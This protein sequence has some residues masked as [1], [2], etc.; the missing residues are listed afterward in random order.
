MGS[1]LQQPPAS[2]QQDLLLSYTSDTYWLK[3]A[4]TPSKNHSKEEEHEML[5]D[6]MKNL[7]SLT[8]EELYSLEETLRAHLQAL[9]ETLSKYDKRHNKQKETGTSK[10]SLEETHQTLRNHEDALGENFDIFMIN[11]S[12]NHI[13]KGLMTIAGDNCSY[14]KIVQQKFSQST[15]ESQT[16]II[17]SDLVGTMFTGT[18]PSHLTSLSLTLWTVLN[19]PPSLY[20]GL[21]DWFTMQV[22]DFDH[23]DFELPRDQIK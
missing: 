10:S 13:L 8:R 6:F 15:S 7:E 17:N 11:V 23:V 2:L 22:P 12:C 14:K 1:Y 4:T 16:P 20:S 18:M 21:K 5:H 9:E 19:S 3:S